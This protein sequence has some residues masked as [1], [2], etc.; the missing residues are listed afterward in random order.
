M[1]SCVT[2]HTHF[3][4]RRRPSLSLYPV[5]EEAIA[6]GKVSGGHG[7]GDQQHYHATHLK[8]LRSR[9]CA[10]YGKCQVNLPMHR[11][12]FVP[13]LLTNL[14]QWSLRIRA[15]QV[16]NGPSRRNWVGGAARTRG[17]VASAV[18][19]VCSDRDCI[20]RYGPGI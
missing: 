18:Y 19:A 8:R 2:L 15:P 7:R 3:L 1:C 9:L 6:W 10:V 16:Q 17:V 4:P 14:V 5:S 13:I 20:Y 12:R 11:E